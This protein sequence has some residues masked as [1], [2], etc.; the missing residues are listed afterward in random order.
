[1]F[2]Q[3]KSIH[4]TSEFFKDFTMKKYRE[5]IISKHYKYINNIATE[6]CGKRAVS[7]RKRAHG[8]QGIFIVPS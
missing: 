8:M 6:V 2:I 4:F 3:L 7:S 1:M 5:L